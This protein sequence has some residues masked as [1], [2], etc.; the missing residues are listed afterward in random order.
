VNEVAAVAL[1]PCEDVNGNSRQCLIGPDD[2]TVVQTQ[3]QGIPV[4][5]NPESELLTNEAAGL[6]LN[7]CLDV[8][9][10][11]KECEIGPDNVT[12]T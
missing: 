3:E 11:P 2:V 5:V 9:G 4:L 1:N 10:N 8:N 12:I 7:P 6:R